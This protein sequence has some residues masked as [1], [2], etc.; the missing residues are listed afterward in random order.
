MTPEQLEQEYE[1]A[2]NE[3]FPE[4]MIYADNRELADWSR[5]FTLKQM[6]GEMKAVNSIIE[7]QKSLIE[8]Y[9]NA[10]DKIKNF[11]VKTL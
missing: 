7:K 9:E 3:R 2:R 4:K 5:K 10:L 8:V 6:E 11:T 1:K